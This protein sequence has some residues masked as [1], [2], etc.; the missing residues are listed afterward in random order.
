ML[1]LIPAPCIASARSSLLRPLSTSSCTA[2]LRL[3]GLGVRGLGVLGFGVLGFRA[4]G[5]RGLGFR[6][7]KLKMSNW[8]ARQP[9]PDAVD[10]VLP[11]DVEEPTLEKPAEGAG[12]QMLDF[13]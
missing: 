8:S 13:R 12:Q 9:A 3:R 2:W 6:A 1:L 10:T 7:G 4:L 11:L 5:V